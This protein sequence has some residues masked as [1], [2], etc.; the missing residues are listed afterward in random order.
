MSLRD[1]TITNRSG[2]KLSASERPYNNRPECTTKSPW[3]P[4]PKYSAN[5][6]QRLGLVSSI[7]AF[8]YEHH[9]QALQRHR[10]MQPQ[11]HMQAKTMFVKR[12]PRKGELHRWGGRGGSEVPRLILIYPSPDRRRGAA[13]QELRRR[14]V[15]SGVA[16][17]WHAPGL[18]NSPPHDI[19]E[20]PE[21]SRI[22]ARSRHL[23]RVPTCCHS[24][25]ETPAT[26]RDPLLRG[27]IQPLSYLY[28]PR[29]PPE[30]HPSELRGSYK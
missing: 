27:T 26:E 28:G 14:Q 18:R 3:E 25:R 20:A 2:S 16:G 7:Q 30:F 29:T 12:W 4:L 10:I 17:A 23:L 5:A 21:L 8:Y 11:S 24:A 13:F 1:P 22:P 6:I 15:S 19:A 9:R